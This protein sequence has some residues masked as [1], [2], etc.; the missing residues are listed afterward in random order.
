M[1]ETLRAWLNGTRDFK[2][3]AS[4][5]NILGSDQK[6]KALF[7]QGHSLYNNFRLQE[8]LTSIFNALKKKE[9]GTTFHSKLAPSSPKKRP[10]EEKKAGDENSAIFADIN[11]TLT[12]LSKMVSVPNPELYKA[13]L[14]NADRLYKEV[15]NK[16]AVLFSMI[17]ANK[18]EDPNR[19]DL[20]ASRSAL[21]IEVVKLY[22]KVSELYDLADYVKLH[23]ALP[24][25]KTVPDFD[26]ELKN[27]PDH[28][29]KN[30]LDNA[31]KACRKLEKKEETPDRV[32]LIQ[33]HLS[34]IE[35]LEER[36][37]SLKQQK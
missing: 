8:E 24:N 35:K 31:R 11:K 23:G 16:R 17:P 15:M 36:W 27:L 1:L 7:S 26:E 28:E 37:L 12:T 29:V 25:Q 6:L 14:D 18:Y 22:N 13:C 21:T 34:K 9:N 30:A 2:T 33:Q 20:V 4:L 5:Y 19:P 3:G 32:I 10:A